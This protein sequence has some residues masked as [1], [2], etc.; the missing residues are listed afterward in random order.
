MS[1]LDNIKIIKMSSDTS[2]SNEVSNEE[3]EENRNEENRN[4]ENENFVVAIVF[5][6]WTLRAI[7]EFLE[8]RLEAT[9][10]EIGMIHIDRTWDNNRRIFKETNRTIILMTRSLFNRSLEEGLGENKKGTDFKIAEYE[11]RK[12]NYPKDGFSNNLHIVLPENLE[13]ESARL[14]IN[15][16]LKVCYRFGVLRNNSATVKIPMK[17]R[18]DGTHKG[19]A[20]VSFDRDCT[21]QPWVRLILHDTR[22]NIVDENYNEHVLMKCFWAKE[23]HGRN[24][25][26][27]NN[28]N[29][30]NGNGNNRNN[31]RNTR[32]NSSPPI[33]V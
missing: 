1:S 8:D 33:N 18:E 10:E 31:R 32:K 30:R 4:G 28:R 27:G 22:L 12:Y 15:E 2:N 29:N 23:R 13:A 24:D 14:Q 26:N 11:L 6:Q 16:K 19:S 21:T 17:S 5:S 25:G 9:K 20:F 3:E 7:V